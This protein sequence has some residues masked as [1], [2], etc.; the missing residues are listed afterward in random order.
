MVGTSVPLSTLT[1]RPWLPARPQLILDFPRAPEDSTEVFVVTEASWTDEGTPKLI[2]KFVLRQVLAARTGQ[3]HRQALVRNC[4]QCCSVM[5]LDC[6]HEAMQAKNGGIKE[7][8]QAREKRK[9]QGCFQR[10][11][12]YMVIF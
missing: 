6:D 11:A 3:P 9:D 8:I 12:Q 4:Y 2:C 1:T 7:T 5:C 10:S